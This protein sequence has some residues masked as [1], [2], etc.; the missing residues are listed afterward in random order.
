[1]ARRPGALTLAASVALLTAAAAL[2][3]PGGQ[4]VAGEFPNRA[5]AGAMAEPSRELGLEALADRLRETDAIGVFAKLAIESEVK[6]LAR[7]F[8][9]FHEGSRIVSRE[10]LRGRFEELRTR[11]VDRLKAGDPA[12]ARDVAR[13]GSTLWLAFYDPAEFSRGIGSTLLAWDGSSGGG[14]GR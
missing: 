6:E 5:P 13:S 8:R 7:A 2:G 1:M 9:F 10:E 14:L 4:A 12:L 3:F 11:I